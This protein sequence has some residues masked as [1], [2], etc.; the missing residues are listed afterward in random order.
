MKVIKLKRLTLENWRA[1]NRTINLTDKTIIRG[2]NG[3]GKSTF[4]DAFFWLILGVDS[5]DRT[6]YDLYDNKREFTYENAI[7]AIVE[8]VFD[9]DGVEY[10]FKRSAK[11]KWSRP[12]NSGVYVKDKADEYIY[13]VDGLAV[14][15]KSYKEQ[16][17]TLLADSDKLKLMLNVRHYLQLDWRVLRKHFADMVG[18]IKES[19]LM[20]DYSEI[21]SLLG[22]FKNIE[23]AKEYLRQAIAPLNKKMDEFEAEINGMRQMLPPYPSNL[24]AVHDEIAN[25]K[26]Q[27]ASVDK[28][29][30]GLGDANKPYIDKRNAELLAIE[31]KKREIKVKKMAYEEDS[32]AEIRKLKKSLAEIEDKNA[33]IVNLNKVHAQQRVSLSEQ[34]A[35]IGEHNTFLQ[36]ELER[37]RQENAEIKARVF[38]EEQ[39]CATCGQPL[40]PEKV[41]EL[42]AAFYENREKAHKQC[43]ERGL[44][45][46]ETLA[47]Q[48]EQANQLS[49][50]I[51]DIPQPMPLLSADE[52]L[53]SIEAMRNTILPFEETQMGKILENHLATMEQSL[54]T[55]SEVDTTELVAKKQE[56]MDKLQEQQSI[57]A[58]AEEYKKGE[59][60][61]NNRVAEQ[62]TSG[63]ELMRLKKLH[64]KCVEREREWASIISKKANQ[65]LAYCKVAM[66]ELSK[67]GELVDVCTITTD[68][69]DVGVANT[70]RQIL[71]GV[72]IALAFQLNAGLRLPI[73]I[74][75]AE[76]IC[77][78]NLPKLENQLI[79][80][81]VSSDSNSLDLSIENA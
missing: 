42:R 48:I 33:D 62:A 32:Y 64:E 12:R 59:Q 81:Y 58:S 43:V 10:T 51:E 56:L 60:R 4:V 79:A 38:S 15:A 21:K 76:Q 73:F 37:L 45:V 40:P 17:E 57:L 67:S 54:T 53:N 13:Y 75:N 36:E 20:G 74:D 34:C 44:K 29:I 69:V 52:I 1:Q 25:I 23:Q 55:I 2:A 16:I 28:E 3:A 31:E 35:S 6:N 71:S 78:F 80:T 39:N 18:E 14:S 61:I 72:D 5:Q 41:D 30:V 66:T 47:K 70:A 65:H 77:D 63:Q 8:G 50:Q 22:R 24:Q 9:A 11:Q 26:E 27:I 19:E 7:P 46:K 68:G 49:K